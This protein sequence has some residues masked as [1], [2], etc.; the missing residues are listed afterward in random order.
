MGV[1]HLYTNSN[2]SLTHPHSGVWVVI[3]RLLF[4]NI[5]INLLVCDVGDTCF[6]SRSTPELSQTFSCVHRILIKV[7]ASITVDGP[8]WVNNAWQTSSTTNALTLNTA[9]ESETHGSAPSMTHFH[10][11][12]STADSKA[13]RCTCE[14]VSVC[15]PFNK[16]FRNL[17]FI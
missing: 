15:V 2:V 7:V 11:S 6:Y 14:C 16:I 5:N 10:P 12:I 1:S 8:A 4:I 13:Q 3:G 9:Q 17:E